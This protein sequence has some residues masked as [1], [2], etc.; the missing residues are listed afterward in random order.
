M[1]RLMQILERLRALSKTQPIAHVK[2]AEETL[3]THTT[4]S[5]AEKSRRKVLRTAKT[6][7]LQFFVDQQAQSQEAPFSV[8]SRT[9]VKDNPVSAQIK[10]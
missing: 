5:K 9:V 8:V 6:K 10:S 4:S 1:H 2:A 3:D 7:A